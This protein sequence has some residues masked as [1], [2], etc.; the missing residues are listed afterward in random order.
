MSPYYDPDGNPLTM[1]EWAFRQEWNGTNVIARDYVDLP[2]GGRAR[3]STIWLG[4][5]MNFGNGPPLIFETMVFFEAD[6]FTTDGFCERTPTRETAL[7]MHAVA[8][9]WAG[10]LGVEPVSTHKDDHA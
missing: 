9:A 8:M 7:A 5:D 4:I 2:G 6:D 3:V 1:W 10:N